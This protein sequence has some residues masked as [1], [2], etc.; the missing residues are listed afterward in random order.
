MPWF[1]LIGTVVFLANAVWLGLGAAAGRLFCAMRSSF[2]SALGA[3]RADK[4][5]APPSGDR[6]GEGWRGFLTP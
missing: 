6:P 5:G 3:V 4:P 2:G 1:K